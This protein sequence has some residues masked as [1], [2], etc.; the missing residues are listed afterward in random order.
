MM[1]YTTARSS[2]NTAVLP[3]GYEDMVWTAELEQGLS[4][5]AIVDREHKKICTK[6]SWQCVD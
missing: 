6:L 4:M 3:G 2:G 5:S 1:A